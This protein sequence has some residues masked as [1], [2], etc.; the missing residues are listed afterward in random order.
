MRL[1]LITLSILFPTQPYRTKILNLSGIIII[2]ALLAAILIGSMPLIGE[3]LY[4]KEID[5]KLN[6][7]HAISIYDTE[8]NFGGALAHEA[9]NTNLTAPYTHNVNENFW[10]AL[11]A[12]EDQHLG[13]WRSMHCIDLL[14]FPRILIH[15]TKE[16][17][18]E[19]PSQKEYQG[20]SSLGMMLAEQLLGKGRNDISQ[21]IKEIFAAAA[22]CTKLG[23]PN[24]DTYKRTVSQFLP[25]YTCVQDNIG[26]GYGLR[27]AAATIFGAKVQ[28]LTK[29]Q[30][31]VLAAAVKHNIILSDGCSKNSRKRWDKVLARA[32]YK[33]AHKAFPN[34][35][36]KIIKEIDKLGNFLPNAKY[37]RS[38]GPILGVG[39]RLS[40]VNRASKLIHNQANI[41]R[42]SIIDAGYKF[43]DIMDI[44]LTYK[45]DDNHKFIKEVNSTIKQIELTLRRKG[46]LANKI[47]YSKVANKNLADITFAVSNQ[48]GNI[49]LL[50]SNKESNIF[51]SNNKRNIASISKILAA[52]YLGKKGEKSNHKY[53]STR[54]SCKRIA[55]KRC[56]EKFSEK[57]F[58]TASE[59]YA[60][61]CN[62]LLINRFKKIK[63]Q[64]LIPFVQGMG[65]D[66]PDVLN[67][68]LNKLLVTGTELK[69]SPKKLLD[70][71]HNITMSLSK[72]SNQTEHQSTS[73]IY[74]A[75]NKGNKPL[76]IKRLINMSSLSKINKASKKFSKQVLRK[77]VEKNGTLST[78]SEIQGI[79]FIYAKTGTS[80]LSKNST[81]SQI[82]DK[83]AIGG[84]K[85]NGKVFSF[86]MLFG[87]PNYESPGGLGKNIP[88]ND[89]FSPIMKTITSNLP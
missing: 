73:L 88:S 16:Y 75:K 81:L 7:S 37:P 83:W 46:V 6:T 64:D 27:G 23:G 57:G 87:A 40:L 48:D 18:S 54:A 26:A 4:G 58:I 1:T 42:K 29:A 63:K 39:Q 84:F 32:K 68:D 5:K 74:S 79:D 34:D 85:K 52:I 76:I 86:V 59:V 61:S 35:E 33:G 77:V 66:I 14:A 8:K 19:K 20:G 11:V 65:F 62:K 51:S 25:I 9:A 31:L 45:F 60:A 80:D 17:L 55:S 69:A 36:Q 41:L 12:M 44:T 3:L 53:C 67:T 71:A 13:S 38:L 22:L 2:L 15:N 43:H 70:I 56:Y 30:S 50:Y 10:R 49:V 72:S 24:S 78:L 21:K 89:L 82:K 28:D 47:S